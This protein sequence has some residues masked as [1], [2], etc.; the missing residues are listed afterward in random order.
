MSRKATPGSFVKGDPRCGRPK[1]C[2]NKVSEDIAAYARSFLES[3]EYRASAHRR[4]LAG[5]APHLETLLYQYAYG[6]P[7]DKLEVTG[8][9]GGPLE[10]IQARESI[11]RKLARLG[12]TADASLPVVPDRP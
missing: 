8:A 9:D 2:R 11:A 7:P 1:G 12:P 4:I 10:F 5:K 3:S 6:K